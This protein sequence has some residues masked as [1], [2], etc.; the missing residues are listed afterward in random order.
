MSTTPRLPPAV[1][2]RPTSV[3][4]HAPELRA[5]FDEMYAELWANGSVGEDVKELV[6]L[7]NAQI[8]DCGL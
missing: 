5:R 4:G 2:D 3:L 8:T 6:R 1:A 7:R